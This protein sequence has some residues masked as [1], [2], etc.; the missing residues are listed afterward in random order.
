MDS[1][2]RM[3]DEVQFQ[4][5]KEATLRRTKKAKFLSNQTLETYIEQNYSPSDETNVT[6]DLTPN[7][8]PSDG[9]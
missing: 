6:D 8:L 5:D 9:K 4:F 1:I 3:L 7:T 2:T